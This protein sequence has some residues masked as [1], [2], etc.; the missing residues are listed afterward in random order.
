[1]FGFHI[2]TVILN[3]FETDISDMGNLKIVAQ[4]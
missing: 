2:I 4:S 1:M 3:Y